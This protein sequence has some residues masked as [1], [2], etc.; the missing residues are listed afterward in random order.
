MAW[1]LFG[2]GKAK[3]EPEP[4]AAS[5]PITELV[6]KYRA[7]VFDS[8][9]ETVL[10]MMKSLQMHLNP[11]NPRQAAQDCTRLLPILSDLKQLSADELLVEAEKSI[12][13]LQSGIELPNANPQHL[14][15][16]A[17]LVDEAVQSVAAMPEED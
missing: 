11:C 16:L 15:R 14:L 2:G 8:K 4:G 10:I 6:G 13:I 1:K 5:F 7:M 9:R 3:S 17:L 12:Q